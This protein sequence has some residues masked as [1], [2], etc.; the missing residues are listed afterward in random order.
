[1]HMRLAGID[2]IW[3]HFLR[4]AHEGKCTA[5][6]DA[7]WDSF[8]TIAWGVGFH[9]LHEQIHVFLTPFF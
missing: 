5:T 3:T 9:V 1:M 7:V 8:T 2:S 6:H 4:C